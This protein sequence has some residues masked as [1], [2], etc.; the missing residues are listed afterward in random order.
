MGIAARLARDAGDTPV[1][2]EKLR[3][4]QATQA[5]LAEKLTDR[6]RAYG[7][8]AVLA[9]T[10][11]IAGS[12]L[13]VEGQIV[14]IDQGNRARRVLIGL[15]AGKSSVAADAQIYYASGTGA[16]RFLS[17]FEGQADSGRMPGAA[18][19]MGAG[20]AVGVGTVATSAAVSGTLHGGAELRRTSDT[21]EAGRLADGLARQ[22][23]QFAV[24]QGWIPPEALR[25]F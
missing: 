10:D 6:L 7:L 12:S 23:G 4:A 3:I 22:I 24:S 17:A 8:P 18:E 13:L 9:T 16:T 2:A 19:T 25:R 15:G 14:S 11:P 21:A 20:A 1:S 5:T